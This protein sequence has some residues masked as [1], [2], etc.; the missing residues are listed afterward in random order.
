MLSQHDRLENLVHFQSA[1]ERRPIA[2]MFKVEL[3]ET[4]KPLRKAPD[5]ECLSD[6][7]CAAQEQWLPVGLDGPV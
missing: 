1:T 3:D 5:G 7:T 6:L 4:V 2:G